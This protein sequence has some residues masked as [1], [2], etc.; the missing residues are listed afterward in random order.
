MKLKN[1]FCA[2]MLMIASAHPGWGR[3]VPEPTYQEMNAKADLVVVATPISVRDT[4][5]KAIFEN[6]T[7][8][9]IVMEATFTS[10]VVFKGAARAATFVLRYYRY[11]PAPDIIVDGFGLVS[12]TAES[13]IKYLMFLTKTADGKYVP[14]NGQ[15][16]PD[17]S[18]LK[19]DDQFRL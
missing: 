7:M 5:E 12:F 1:L 19:L 17:L 16:D 8:P 9:A 11:N 6:S 4:G 10:E 13:N 18:I 14:V 3:I 2:L 15:S